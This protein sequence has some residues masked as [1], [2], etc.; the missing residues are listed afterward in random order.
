MP[1]GNLLVRRVRRDQV[2]EREQEDPDDVHEVPIEAGQLDG[3]MIVGAVA[4]AVGQPGQRQQYGYADDH[5]ERV[6]A[7][8]GE[9]ERV[10]DLRRAG[11]RALEA[12]VGAGDQVVV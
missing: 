6:Q 5:V 9:V 4:A 10:V 3:G 8:H 7:R 11:Q 1:G 2:Q 12:E